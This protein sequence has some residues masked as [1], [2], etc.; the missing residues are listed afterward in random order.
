[1][2]PIEAA[3]Y[4]AQKRLRPILITSL[5]TILGMLPI[6]FG[7]GEGGKILQPLGIAVAGGLWVSTLFTLYIVP[8]LEVNYYIG[9]KDIPPGK[10]E[11]TKKEE[12]KGPA[13]SEISL[14]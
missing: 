8:S 12:R 1:M 4:S 11:E 6:A 13:S 7:M 5:T 14:R 3:L 9:Q 10:M 2:E